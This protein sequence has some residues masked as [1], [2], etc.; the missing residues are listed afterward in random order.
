M[1]KRNQI[2]ADW[3][4]L[5][6]LLAG[7]LDER[8][9][10]VIERHLQD[11]RSCRENFD[12]WTMLLPFQPVNLDGAPRTPGMTERTLRC[13]WSRLIGPYLAGHMTDLEKGRMEAHVV[14]C[15]PCGGQLA[16]H[17]HSPP[18]TSLPFLY[19]LRRWL[20]RQTR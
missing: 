3:E 18:D 11:C 20:L 19:R 15:E 5:G 12:R 1:G 10:Y 7:T 16:V 17:L 9:Q 4:Q 14:K 6:R 8:A 13:G 2:H